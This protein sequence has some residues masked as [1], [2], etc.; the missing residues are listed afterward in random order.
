MAYSQMNYRNPN[1]NRIDVI[2]TRLFE[3]MIN[4]AEV[5]TEALREHDEELSEAMM[6]RH[7]ELEL[8]MERVASIAAKLSASTGG[9]RT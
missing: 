4:C 9:V 7:L 1:W 6:D 2:E 3:Q 5:G 8:R